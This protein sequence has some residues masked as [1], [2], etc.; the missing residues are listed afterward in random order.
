MSVSRQPFGYGEPYAP[1]PYFHIPSPVH[2]GRAII[3]DSIGY[4]DQYHIGPRP[5]RHLGFEGP[6][7][8]ELSAYSGNDSIA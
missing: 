6:I 4:T 1:S 8:C 5:Y 2:T 7:R 3:E